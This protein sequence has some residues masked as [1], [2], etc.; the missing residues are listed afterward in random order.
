MKVII[1]Y[2]TS[3]AFDN[4]WSCPRLFIM[5]PAAT[6]GLL[7][8]IMVVCLFHGTVLSTTACFRRGR[9]G[10]PG[11]S[12]MA[13]FLARVNQMVIQSS[14]FERM[15]RMSFVH[16]LAVNCVFEEGGKTGEKLLRGGTWVKNKW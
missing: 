1:S 4:E 13:Y 14:S 16:V 9:E 8:C 2:E 6:G 10:S 11:T 5:F 3:R 7:S 15:F 12:V